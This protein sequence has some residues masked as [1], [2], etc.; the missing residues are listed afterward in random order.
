MTDPYDAQN[1]KWTR[2][3]LFDSPSMKQQ[4]H[5]AKYADGGLN[6]P[7]L[8]M[9]VVLENQS[10]SWLALDMVKQELAALTLTQYPGENV[11][12]CTQDIDVKY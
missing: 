1:L 11:K 4:L 12:A 8:W 6:G 5:L 9:Y 10:D 2:Q 3:F 7:M